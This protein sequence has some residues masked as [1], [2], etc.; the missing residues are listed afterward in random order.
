[1]NK[2][3]IRLLS[4]EIL[5]QRD[6]ISTEAATK[7]S[8]ILPFIQNLEYNIFDSREL[9]AEAVSDIGSKKGEKV[10]YLILKDNIPIF[11]IECKKWSENLDTHKNQLIRYFHT[12]KAKIGILTN[13]IIYKFFTDLE[14]PNILDSDPFFTFN[15][16]NF[17]DLDLENLEF[18]S[19]SK[20]SQESILHLALKLKY[21]FK[22]KNLLAQELN[23]PSKDFTTLFMNRVYS[24]EITDNMYSDF[25]CI[26]KAALKEFLR[27]G[28]IIEIEDSK[29]ITTTEEELVF[30][31]TLINLFPKYSKILTYKDYVGHFSVLLN[32]NQK[33]CVCK[34]LFNKRNKY[35]LLID[36]IGI[37][38]KMPFSGDFSILTINKD[39][40]EGRI[41]SLIKE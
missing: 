3:L 18:F 9:L 26:I 6:S 15:I 13:G 28:E 23:S 22:I 33:L 11:I 1:M 27:D 39:I 25:A 40:I 35:I 32:G 7:N 4:E 17:S 24:G 34:A 5:N 20:Y 10:D 19:K 2:Q 12:S 16:L 29:K 8:F 41:K 36:S 38:T 31:N 14:Q 30:Y 21:I 37:E